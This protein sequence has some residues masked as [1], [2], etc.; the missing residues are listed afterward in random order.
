MRRLQ[1]VLLVQASAEGDELICLLTKECV[2]R[3]TSGPQIVGRSVSA[4]K[5]GVEVTVT[6]I[7]H[8]QMYDNEADAV[9]IKP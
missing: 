3:L 7:G 5:E 1:Q 9:Q 4:G 2:E 8:A 6:L